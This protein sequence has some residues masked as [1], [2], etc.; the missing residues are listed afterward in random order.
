MDFLTP[1][2]A[3]LKKN[4]LEDL[5]NFRGTT[6]TPILDFWLRLP[7][8]SNDTSID[9]I[10]T[11]ILIPNYCQCVLYYGKTLLLLFSDTI[12][13]NCKRSLNRI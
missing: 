6:D 10:F 2:N 8:V 3:T 5:S 1:S 12:K 13:N 4:F 11:V 9:G 7:W